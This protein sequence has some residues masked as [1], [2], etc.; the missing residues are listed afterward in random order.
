M[1]GRN[2][3]RRFVDGLPAGT[4][5]VIRRNERGKR[6]DTVETPWLIEWDVRREVSKKRRSESRR[7][8]GRPCSPPSG[9]DPPGSA[10]HRLVFRTNWGEKCFIRYANPSAPERGLF[11]SRDDR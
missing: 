5:C 11:I 4:K 9:S 1:Q 8:R 2:A 3:R 10:C 6:N 7:E